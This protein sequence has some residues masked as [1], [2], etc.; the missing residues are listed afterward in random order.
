MK[1]PM[2]PVDQIFPEA[3]RLGQ[4]LKT[5]CVKSPFGC[6]KPI[7]SFR[8][9]ISAREHKISGLCQE[10]QDKIFEGGE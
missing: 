5:L 9:E 4:I 8:D 7:Q 2:R 1:E 6:G 10:C 3:E